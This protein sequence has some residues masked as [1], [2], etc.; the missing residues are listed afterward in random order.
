VGGMRHECPVR[1]ED[2][3]PYL[4]GQ[5]P[6][7]EAAAVAEAV[8]ACASCTA[9]VAR[10][11]PVV[12]ALA[13][14]NAPPDEAVPAAPTA[15]LERVLASVREERSSSRRRLRRRV[16]LAAAAVL[17]VLAT[18]AG[19]ALLPDED[20]RQV[21]LVS[22]TGADGSVEVSSRGWGTALDLKV[23]G[24]T[25]GT[26]YGAWLAD[27]SG[28]RV[29]AGSFR[30]GTDGSAHLDL[31]ASMSLQDASAVGVTEIGGD[32]ILTGDLRE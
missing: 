29:P 9:E 30:P 26:S 17:V 27:G 24:L 20:G 2:L 32:D 10:L 6:P 13:L 4:L 3:G 31:S 19:V 15:A 14:G 12:Q 28:D 11:R 25:P 8:D 16:G 7:V 23:H 5:L 21:P 1:A 18:A 22:T